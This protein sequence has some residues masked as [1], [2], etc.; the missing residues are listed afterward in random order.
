MLKNLPIIPYCTFPKFL[1]IILFYS[2][3]TINYSFLFYCVSY[4]ITMQKQLYYYL[5]NRLC[6]LTALI[7]YLTVLLECLDLFAKQVAEH[8]KHLRGPEPA[9]CEFWLHH[10]LKLLYLVF[11]IVSAILVSNYSCF[12]LV[13]SL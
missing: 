10:C 7:E 3:S 6:L 13:H 12:M 4:N 8:S 9:R 11:H 5:H 2:H 1:P